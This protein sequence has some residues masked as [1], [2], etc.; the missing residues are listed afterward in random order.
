MSIEDDILGKKPEEFRYLFP[1]EI[2]FVP[3]IA[4]PNDPEFGLDRYIEL[5]SLG[6]SIVIEDGDIASCLQLFSAERRPGKYTQFQGSLIGGLTFGSHRE[7]ARRIFGLPI[8]S[9]AGGLGTGLMGS[10][11]LPW[12][13]FRTEKWDVNIT[14]GEDLSSINF[15]SVSLHDDS[16]AFGDSALN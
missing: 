11:G 3:E 16:I 13:L 7:D 10:V 9:S 5:C 2:F 8:R 6:M 4:K 1:G 15:V 12:D 14:Y